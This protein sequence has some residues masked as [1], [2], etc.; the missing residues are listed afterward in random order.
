MNFYQ[1]M[2]ILPLKKPRKSRQMQFHDKTAY[3]WGLRYQ[4]Y[5]SLSMKPVRRFAHFMPPWFWGQF[6]RGSVLPLA[7]LTD[8]IGCA[9]RVLFT[10]LNLLRAVSFPVQGSYTWHSVWDFYLP[11]LDPVNFGYIH[12][13]NSSVASPFIFFCL[14]LS[15]LSF[16]VTNTIVWLVQDRNSDRAHN[17][18]LKSYLPLQ[19]KI[20]MNSWKMK[21]TTYQR[22]RTDQG[23]CPRRIQA[24]KSPRQADQ[25]YEKKFGF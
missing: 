19:N 16:F 4:W 22:C 1:R 20:C 15:F 17:W 23:C 9:G 24:E 8:Q 6:D 12:W 21:T 10:S 18:V 25:A 7:W 14:S 5:S 11:S 13:S 3:V 2:G